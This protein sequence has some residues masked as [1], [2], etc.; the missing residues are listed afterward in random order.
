MFVGKDDFE[1]KSGSTIFV[2]K[3]GDH[4]FHSIEEDLM[5]L[6]LFSPAEYTNRE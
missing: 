2:E 4:K 3:N 5:I 1:V 6:V